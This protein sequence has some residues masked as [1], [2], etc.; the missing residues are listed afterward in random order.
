MYDTLALLTG[1]HGPIRRIATPFSRLRDPVEAIFAIAMLC[2]LV[3]PAIK[4]H[5]HLVDSDARQRGCRNRL[6]LQ[7]TLRDK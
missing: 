1:T 5:R 3:H 7:A 4:S 6:A 2:A